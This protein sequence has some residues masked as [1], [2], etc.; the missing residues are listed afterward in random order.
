MNDFIA[1]LE[2]ELVSAARRRA[3]RRR[4][5]RLRLVPAIAVAAAALA[6]MFVVGAL[7][8]SQ[9]ADDR[10]A[11][12]AGEGIAVTIPPALGAQETERCPH[13]DGWTAYAPGDSTLAVFRRPETAEDALPARV[14]WLH[15]SVVDADNARRVADDLWLVPAMG[16]DCDGAQNALD[17]GVCLV[18][19]SGPVARCF[20]DTAIAAAKAVAVT[21]RG[22]VAGIVPDGVTGVEIDGVQAT[23]ADNAFEASLPGVTAGDHVQVRLVGAP[24]RCGPSPQAYAAVPALERPPTGNPTRQL[25]MAMA[26]NGGHG[27]WRDSAREIKTPEGLRIWVVADVPCD[28]PTGGPEQVCLLPEGG[29]LACQTPAAIAQGGLLT[30]F[31]RDNRQVVVAGIAPEG[32]KRVE[33]HVSDLIYVLHPVARVYGTSVR[34]LPGQHVEVRLR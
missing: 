9:T 10:P 20:S 1:D 2:A 24:K 26:G 17:P 23:V 18:A 32:A 13:L 27:A 22:A 12:P 14:D 34:V 15:A 3:T 28:R 25:E 7:D 30:Q 33:V 11:P 19:E 5:P 21:R 16:F 8:R 4:L 29:P 6:A 31:E